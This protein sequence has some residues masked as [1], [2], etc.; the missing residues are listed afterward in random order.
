MQHNKIIHEYIQSLSK[1]LSR[2]DKAEAEDVIREIE[3]HIYD[4]LES[5]PGE[6]EPEEILEGFGSPRELAAQYVDHMVVGS[7]PPEGFKAIQKVK[8]GATKG[9]YFAMNLFGYGLAFLFIVV[10]LYKFDEPDLVGVW[11]TDSG[12]SW[13]IGVSSIPPGGTEELLGWWLVPIAIGGGL[14]VAYLTRRVLSILK[15]KI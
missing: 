11:G 2:L 10:G 13:I 6:W 1:Y 7:P 3:S 9:L 12:E 8:R 15:E 14:A 5:Q 4:V